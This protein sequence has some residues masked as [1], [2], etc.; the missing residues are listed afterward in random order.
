MAEGNSFNVYIGSQS[1]PN[2]SVDWDGP[3]AFDPS[4]DYKI[5]V[6]KTGRLHS[7]RFASEANVQWAVTGFALD[8]KKVGTR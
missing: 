6:R 3:Y 2:S 8:V 5:D 1:S 4:S 7:I